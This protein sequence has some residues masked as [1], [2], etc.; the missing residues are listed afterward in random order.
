MAAEVRAGG[1]EMAGVNILEDLLRRPAAEVAEWA[2]EQASGLSKSNIDVE[3]LPIF[4]VAGALQHIPMQQKQALVRTAIVG[5][6]DLPVG[7]R[8][9]AV[10][11]A[12][13]TSDIVQQADHLELQQYLER[14]HA[15]VMQRLA[16]AG[17][18]S[19]VVDASPPVAPDLNREAR[20]PLRS[21]SRSG[22][23]PLLVENFLRLVKEAKFNEMPQED[24]AVIAKE[25]QKEGVR[26]I[27]PQQLID[28][29]AELAPEER[30]KLTEVLVDA[31][32]VP[33]EQRGVLEEAVRPGGY[34][35]K[36][37]S[38]LRL[39]DTVCEYHWAFVALPVAEM[40]LAFALGALPCRTPLVSWLRF[41]SILALLVA[42]AVYCTGHTLA[43]VYEKLSADP[44]GAV[45]RWQTV[46]EDRDM[47][48]R[49]ETAVPGV[50][51]ETYRDAGIG[52]L[53]CLALVLVGAVWAA[54]GM[55]ELLATTFLGCTGFTLLVCIFF[56][57]LRIGIV[58]ALVMGLFYVLDEIQRHRSRS[59]MLGSSLLPMT[60]DQDERFLRAA[61]LP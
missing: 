2:L 53:V 21:K 11:L 47:R 54:I 50:D 19:V 37:S 29:V 43:P 31:H 33:E 28:V 51:F 13:Q 40:F 34:A 5:F 61:A 30:E 14:E 10:R 26:L 22:G 46:A 45:Q 57:G 36:L 20:A 23:Q 32:V 15:I 3:H 59:P 12:M 35:D 39:M 8:A 60:E 55:L 4:Q 17:G 27:Q 49:L 25:A 44:V 58:L 42:G 9:Q 16:G 38:F 41:D 48:T 7:K 1:N 18:S 56:I 52:F 24:V 6:G